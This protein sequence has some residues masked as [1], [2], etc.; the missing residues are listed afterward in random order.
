M[1]SVI[2]SEQEFL[3]YRAK[4]KTE[5]FPVV[6]GKLPPVK[7]PPGRLPPNEFLPWLGSELGLGLGAIFRGEIFQGGFS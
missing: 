2:I 5:L 7:S 4:I 1:I 3:V 6:T